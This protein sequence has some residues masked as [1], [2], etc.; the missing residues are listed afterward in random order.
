M[1]DSDMYEQIERTVTAFLD[2]FLTDKFDTESIHALLTQNPTLLAVL[3]QE[4]DTAIK[5]FNEFRRVAF[6]SYM[7]NSIE[8]ATAFPHD[9]PLYTQME[10]N[11]ERNSIIG[12]QLHNDPYF[13]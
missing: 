13:C 5:R 7:S 12:Q 6:P 9:L 10:L 4:F 11:E 3:S 2:R 1:S 8:L